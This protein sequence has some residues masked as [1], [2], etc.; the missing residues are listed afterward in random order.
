MGAVT[1]ALLKKFQAKLVWC[2]SHIGI[3][4]NEIADDL[5]QAATSEDPIDDTQALL[6]NRR[7]KV[8]E[9]PSA[10]YRDIRWWRK[11]ISKAKKEVWQTRWN[12]IDTSLKKW[13]P[14]IGTWKSKLS[15]NIQAERTLARLRLNRHHSQNIPG[16]DKRSCRCGERTLTYN[17]AISHCPLWLTQRNILI[18]AMQKTLE[19]PSITA[20]NLMTKTLE[21][22]KNPMQEWKTTEHLHSFLSNTIGA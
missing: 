21:Q 14:T 1:G 13:K 2:P 18:Q 20:A 5:A 17:H 11:R 3:P 8:S 4:G 7:I 15:S 10:A 19:D 22:Q 12:E 16:K 6:V 9:L